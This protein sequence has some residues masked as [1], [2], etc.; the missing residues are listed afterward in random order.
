MRRASTVIVD[1]LR[2]RAHMFNPHW[3]QR[4]HISPPSKFLPFPPIRLLTGCAVW[5]Q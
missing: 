3:I 5:P 2:L 4:G 1:A